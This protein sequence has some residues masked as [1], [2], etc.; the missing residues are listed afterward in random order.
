MSVLTMGMILVLRWLVRLDTPRHLR[1][2][3]T[4]CTVMV[5]LSLVIL[6]SA[7]LRDV[8]LGG[9]GQLCRQ[10]RCAC[11]CGYS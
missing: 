6:T 2:F 1:L 11:M 4:L 8:L 5:G 10:R 3:N 7:W 9:R